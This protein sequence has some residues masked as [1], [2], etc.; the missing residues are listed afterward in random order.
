MNAD[1]RDEITRIYQFLDLDLP[2]SIV[3]AMTRVANSSAHQGHRYSREQFGLSEEAAKGRP[4][5]GGRGKD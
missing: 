5:N 2:A 3:A 4:E 1:W